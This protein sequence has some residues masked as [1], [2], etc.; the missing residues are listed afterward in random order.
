MSALPSGWA[1]ASLATIANVLDRFRVPINARERANRQ[2]NVP[3]Y[4]AT[5]QVGWIDDH[6][7][8]EE[9]V[10][11]GEDGAPFLERDKTKAYLINGP[12]WVNNHVHVLR[13]CDGICINRYLL[14]YL[15]YFDYHGYA[16]GT[17]RLK[18]TQGEM[19]RIPVPL[20][21]PAEQ[22]RLVAAIDEQF[23]RLDA[24]IAALQR[25]R[26]NLKRMR[27]AVLQAAIEGRLANSFAGAPLNHPSR[28]GVV[29]VGDIA[30][31]SGGITKNPK[32][33]PRTNPVPFLRVA[34]V[35]RD[36]LDL[37]DVHEIEVFEGELDKLRLRHG[38]L[39][40]VEGNGSP[41]EIGR[42]AIWDGSIDPCVHQNHLIRVRPGASVL[43][44]YLN[45]FWNAPSSIAT[46]RAVASSTS[47]LYTLSTGKVRSIPV[48]LPPVAAQ[49]RIVAEVERRLSFGERLDRELV[50]MSALGRSLR[51]SV[52]SAAFSGMLV[53]Q[54]PDDEPASTLL[55]DI[56]LERPSPNGH[57]PAR[58]RSQRHRKVIA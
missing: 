19:N 24:G 30:E 3:Y 38:D 56:S 37:N 41:D 21:P 45:L 31:V 46:L 2:G 39:L 36:A 42:S 1:E 23:S 10:L 58:A 13:A 57:R 33:L 28:W 15:N 6:L 35:Q 18:L 22:E 54:D 47:G 17:T 55:E 53:Q 20:A 9:L 49:E 16:N 4:G 48:V 44:A 40:V 50:K 7:F 27:A 34:N 32:R 25:V 51:S 43:P 14:H 29:T 12:A 26:Q 11:L 52:L 8:D 5:G